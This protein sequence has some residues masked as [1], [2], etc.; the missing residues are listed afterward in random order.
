[1][2]SDDSIG[3]LAQK[4]KTGDREAE[5]SLLLQ[6]R[7]RL[8]AVAKLKIANTQDAQDLAHDALTTLIEKGYTDKGE[9]LRD[10][11]GW[12][13]GIL[14]N[15][16]GNYYRR[17]RVRKSLLISM[18][19]E[20]QRG[21]DE[22]VTHLHDIP[23]DPAPPNGIEILVEDL[24]EAIRQLCDKCREFFQAILDAFLSGETEVRPQQISALS[25]VEI[26]RCRKK[27]KKILN[28]KAKGWV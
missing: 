6:L 11:L 21:E 25:Y 24:T 3:V 15:K 10:V 17:T 26:C 12:A 8:L 20:Q 5:N 4:A 27:L 2:K 14:N 13:C 23:D 7:E 16:I 19:G 22:R 18:F 9:E 1:M 28:K